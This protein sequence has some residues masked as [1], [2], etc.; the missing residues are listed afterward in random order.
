M[1]DHSAEGEGRKSTM[2][3]LL[4]CFAVLV[5]ISA[6]TARPAEIDNHERQDRVRIYPIYVHLFQLQLQFIPVACTD[7]T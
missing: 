6:V 2:S 7:G 1:P 3:R 5:V 4:A